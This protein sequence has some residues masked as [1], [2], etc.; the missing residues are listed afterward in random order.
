MYSFIPSFPTKGQ[1][2]T[3]T[4][5]GSGVTEVY[6]SPSEQWEKKTSSLGC[7]GDEIQPSYLGMIRNNSTD[8][9]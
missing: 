9:Y 6:P 2:S 5:Q 4:F 1:P 7:K 3:L 8:T